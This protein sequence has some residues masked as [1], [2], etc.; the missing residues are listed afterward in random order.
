MERNICYRSNDYTMQITGEA[1]V[2][3]NLIMG[4]AAG[5]FG[6]TDNQG[7]TRD[8]QFVHNT[9]INTGIGANLSSWAGRTGLIFANNVVYSRDAASL[10]F[11]HG[12]AGVQIAGNVVLGPVIG[13]TEGYIEGNGLADF[14]DVTWDFTHRDARPAPN[15]PFVGAGLVDFAVL[16]DLAGQKR[17]GPVTAGAFS[18]P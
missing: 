17:Q 16:L 15:S 10:R 11:P 6:S 5:A 18:A 3:N 14:I 12:S 1:I 8:L 9:L 2:R 7:T 4:G 13:A